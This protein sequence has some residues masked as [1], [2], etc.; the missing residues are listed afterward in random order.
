MEWPHGWDAL[1]PGAGASFEAELARQ[2]SPGH[3]LYGL[4]VRA[5]GQGGNG[6][7][8]LFE[9]AD[10][11]GRVAVAHLT[12]AR[13]AEQ[14]PWPDSAVF[15]SRA[16]WLASEGGAEAAPGAAPDRGGR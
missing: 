4:A 12:W 10:G 9:M 6:D 3:R 14:P 15:G 5:V 13:R 8:V 16:A 7:D 2:L 11:S 1:D